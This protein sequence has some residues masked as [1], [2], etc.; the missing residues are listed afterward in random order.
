NYARAAVLGCA[1]ALL[2]SG[3]V[4][5]TTLSGGNVSYTFDESALGLFG[6]ASVVD[7]S[8][9]FAPSGFNAT[10]TSLYAK[11]TI[12]ITVT[13][14]SGYSLG[15]FSLSENGGYTLPTSGGSATA[16]GS[17][18][19]IDIEGTT[20]NQITETF[21]GVLDG[22][23][24]DAAAT[25]ALPATGWGGTDGVVSSV[26][27]TL[28]NQL[29]ALGGASISKTGVGISA[30]ALPVPEASTYAMLLAGLGL[31]GFMA[32]RRTHSTL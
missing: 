18:K 1:L 28:S 26:T 31:V 19:A 8:L 32:Y 10:G 24:W 21:N 23:A 12:N 22:G 9:V 4:A 25:I 15:G 6:S 20:G 5:A 3:A 7:G 27:L 30:T 13:A 16:T 17:F 11:E 14:A 2:S 29:F